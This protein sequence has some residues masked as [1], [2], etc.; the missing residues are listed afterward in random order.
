LQHI[1]DPRICLDEI[2]NDRIYYNLDQYKQEMVMR[3]KKAMEQVKDNLEDAKTEQ[4]EKYDRTSK[5]K[6]NYCLGDLVYVYKTNLEG[7][8]KLKPKWD[9]P[10]RIVKILPNNLTY[11]L[12]HQY[13]E[14][15]E[16]VHHNRMKKGF[17]SKPWKSE[18]IPSDEEIEETISPVYIR[19]P[20]EFYDLFNDHNSWEEWKEYLAQSWLQTLHN[21]Q[22]KKGNIRCSSDT[23]D[24]EPQTQPN[25]LKRDKPEVKSKEEVKLEETKELSN[26]HTLDSPS[27]LTQKLLSEQTPSTRCEL[28]ESDTDN[29]STELDITKPGP[30][31]RK[32]SLRERLWR[33][34]KKPEGQ[35][36]VPSS[37]AQVAK[38]L[39]KKAKRHEERWLKTF[40]EATKPRSNS[41]P[42]KSHYRDHGKTCQYYKEE[43]QKFGIQHSDQETEKGRTSVAPSRLIF[44]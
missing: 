3:M 21:K 1:R 44:K 11:V 14:K 25:G 37:A 24:E 27:V 8:K 29:S 15:E 23:S 41:E 19:R 18:P 26:C 34:V 32:T 12:K 36:Q 4:K 42:C 7:T 35:P 6:T 13:N 9:G 30:S 20:Y 43:K 31:L 5:N 33:K 16:V 40:D 10:Y 17:F 22:E 39:M 38:S 2:Q 28:T